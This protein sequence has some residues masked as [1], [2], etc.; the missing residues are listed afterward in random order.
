MQEVTGP[1]V[2]MKALLLGEKGCFFSMKNPFLSLRQSP[3]EE[4]EEENEEIR[5]KEDRSDRSSE[6]DLKTEEME[7]RSV[8]G[9]RDT[10]T[11]AKQTSWSFFFF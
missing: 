1:K 2:S 8:P 11:G 9:K 6:I 10:D 4:E 3:E 7:K 5:G